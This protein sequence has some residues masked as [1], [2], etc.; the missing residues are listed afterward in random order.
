LQIE[1]HLIASFLL[2]PCFPF[3]RMYGW[4]EVDPEMYAVATSVTSTVTLANSSGDTVLGYQPVVVA[5]GHGVSGPTFVDNAA[6]REY[7]FA[8][9]EAKALDMESAALA[10][11]ATQFG[12]KFIIFRSLSDLAGGDTEGNVMGVFFSIAASNAVATMSAFLHALPVENN[13]GEEYPVPVDHTPGEDT[14]GLLGVLSFW[15]P[16]L[17]ALKAIMNDGQPP[18]ELVFGGRKF[19][20]GTIHGADVVATLTGVSISNT[21]LTTALMAMLYP[22][23][24][25]IIGGGIAGGVDPS[26]KVGDVVVPE[27]WAMYQMQIYGREVSAGVFEPPG[28]E[29][30]NVVG[31]T[32]G[33]FDGVDRYLMG[34]AACDPA[35][36]SA[37]GMIFPQSIQTPNPNDPL[38]ENQIS[39]G[40][41]RKVSVIVT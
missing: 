31:K 22:G 13:S 17:E 33:A 35:D 25:R 41:T 3:S 7:V 20:R 6:F 24:E 29:A 5:G 1:S 14:P 10:H 9:F 30:G 26:L 28:F 32:C 38:P 34:D 40:P 19:Y 23:V 8:T 4:F 11:V 16:E 2:L 37:F 39:E 15:Q 27:R 21:A 36:A 18:E 12:K